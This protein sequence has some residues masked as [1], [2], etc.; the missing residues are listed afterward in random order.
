MP[1]VSPPRRLATYRARPMSGA[2][3]SRQQARSLCLTSAR[4][5]VEGDSGFKGRPQGMC[6]SC[7]VIERVRAASL[8]GDHREGLLGDLELLVGGPFPAVMTSPA[9]GGYPPLDSRMSLAPARPACRSLVEQ[10]VDVTLERS[11]GTRATHRPFN[12]GRPFETRLRLFASSRNLAFRTPD[13]RRGS[14][15]CIRDSVTLG[16]H[17]V[18]P[19]S[20]LGSLRPDLPRRLAVG[21]DLVELDLVLECVHGAPEAVVWV[22]RAA[23]ARR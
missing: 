23:H 3:E 7:D 10:V 19:D 8:A 2:H 21:D 17:R 15:D 1:A 12:S 5:L 20:E 4:N 9:A 6:E 13:V 11:Q 22:C 18:R 14:A 16:V